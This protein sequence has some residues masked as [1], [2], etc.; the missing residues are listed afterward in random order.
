MAPI[1]VGRY[2]PVNSDL[3]RYVIF[4]DITEPKI[5]TTKVRSCWRDAD[6][7][8]PENQVVS[9]CRRVVAQARGLP[10]R[11]GERGK[12]A[13]VGLGAPS[14]VLPRSETGWGGEAEGELHGKVAGDT[15]TTHSFQI[16]TI[17]LDR[18]IFYTC[19]AYSVLL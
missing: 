11:S 19:L 9:A 4:G 6:G 13:G 7:C 12:S 3:W 1:C 15:L 8:W 2:H 17:D 14:C 5:V 18:E 16:P 10:H